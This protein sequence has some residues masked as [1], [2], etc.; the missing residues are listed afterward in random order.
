MTW[1]KILVVILE[2]RFKQRYNTNVLDDRKDMYGKK[3]SDNSEFKS[4]SDGLDF[5]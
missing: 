1:K 4:D 3:D 5:E 2:H